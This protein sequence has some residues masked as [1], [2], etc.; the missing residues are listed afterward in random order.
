MFARFRDDNFF[1]TAPVSQ[2]GIGTWVGNTLVPDSVGNSCNANSPAN[3]GD[4]ECSADT[5]LLPD[6]RSLAWAEFGHRHGY[7]LIYFHSQA[8]SRLEAGLLHDTAI[9]AG[10]RLIAIDRP[11][12]GKSDFRTLKRHWEFGAD[13]QALISH[14]KLLNPGLIS[15]AGGAPFALALAATPG[16]AISFVTLLAPTPAPAF[17]C[18]DFVRAGPGRAGFSYTSVFISRL[19]TGVMQ[20]AL[21]LRQRSAG[22]KISAKQINRQLFR[23]K[24]QVCH[25]DRRLLDTPWV[26]DLLLRDAQEAT[27]KGTRGAAQDSVMALR[28]WDFNLAD[29]KVPVHIWQGCADNLTPMR[30]ANNLARSLPAGVLHALRCQGHFFHGE[31]ALDIFQRIRQELQSVSRSALNR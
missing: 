16:V 17:G 15:W 4:S 12:I 18:S 24:E 14:L 10:F 30:C 28:G 23:L 8:G 3:V 19:M 20:C 29:I 11:G 22:K 2:S 25:A 13:V 27:L 7:P 26:S 6:G 1:L 9:A 5:L 21:G 31:S